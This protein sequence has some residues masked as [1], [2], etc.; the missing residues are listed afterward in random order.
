MV[1][2]EIDHVAVDHEE[3]VANTSSYISQQQWWYLP[4]VFI[5]IPTK[6]GIFAKELSCK[7]YVY[8]NI[9]N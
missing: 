8:K 6:E 1:A 4:W 3:F 5:V 9:D 7:E 2:E